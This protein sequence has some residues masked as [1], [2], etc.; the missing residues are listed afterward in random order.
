MTVPTLPVSVVVCTVERPALLEECLRSLAA[1]R[2]RAAEIVV[3]DQG[4]DRQSAR[5]VQ[6]YTDAGARRVPSPTTGVGAAR[7]AGLQAATHEIVLLTDD[8]CTV[9]PDWVARAFAHMSREPVGI[10]TGRVLAAGDPELVPSTI[11]LPAAK[12]YSAGTDAA[13][14]YT[15]NMA[16]PR[17]A[18]LELGGFDARIR[19]AASDNDLCYRWLKAGRPMSY[20]PDLVVWHHDWRSPAELAQRYFEYGIGSGMFYAKH[21]R[22]GDWSVVRHLRTDVSVGL[23]GVAA[24]V[25]GRRRGSG[26][27]YRTG[28]LRGLPVGLVRGWRVFRPG[29]QES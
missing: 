15:G 17:A 14:L 19:P 20:Q 27:D 5:A 16:A 6:S 29:R 25:L 11:D 12:T 23:R 8:D 2:P 28:L 18:L 24:S 1:C 10:V 26:P 22:A 7:N 3:V 9:A 21:I 13:V 4:H